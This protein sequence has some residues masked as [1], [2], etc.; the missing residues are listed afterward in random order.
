MAKYLSPPNDWI[1]SLRLAIH[2]TSAENRA[3]AQGR[4]RLASLMVT[5][6][7]PRNNSKS[8]LRRDGPP[9]TRK[10]LSQGILQ[11][12]L[13]IPLTACSIELQRLALGSKLVHGHR[14][15]IQNLFFLWFCFFDL[16]G[17]L[18]D[19]LH[20]LRGWHYMKVTGPTHLQSYLPCLRTVRCQISE[21][22]YIA[23][24]LLDSADRKLSSCFEGNTRI[25]DIDRRHGWL[26]QRWHR[27]SFP[28][29]DDAVEEIA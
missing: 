25:I 28:L 13:H 27:Y 16:L 20:G 21:S 6:T 2:I 24:L 3:V 23:W 29:R 10:T 15:Q 8:K 7:C 17:R 5:T 22:N 1:C 4:Y 11:P 14:S 26:H 9:P 19:R 12:L 18:A